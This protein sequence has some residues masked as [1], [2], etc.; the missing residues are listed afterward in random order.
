M[1]LLGPLTAVRI[2]LVVAAGGVLFSCG[3]SVSDGGGSDAHQ[4]GAG[5][6]RAGEVPAV[7][8]HLQCHEEGE[9]NTSFYCLG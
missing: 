2:I 1:S 6:G 5:E 4:T 9:G 8:R 3:V 7:Q